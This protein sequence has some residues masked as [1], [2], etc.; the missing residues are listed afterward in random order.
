MV[1]ESTVTSWTGMVRAYF[2]GASI[3]ARRVHYVTY[4]KLRF[5]VRVVRWASHSTGELIF[6]QITSAPFFTG[7][8][9]PLCLVASGFVIFENEARQAPSC[10]VSCCETK[11]RHQQSGRKITDISGP[12]GKV[13]RFLRVMKPYMV[14]PETGGRL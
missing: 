14:T 6:T 10:Q 9:C 8:H 3:R 2:R 13:Y 4:V 11:L 5:E 7:N 12:A 1:S